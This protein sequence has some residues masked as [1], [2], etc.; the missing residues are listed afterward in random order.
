MSLLKNYTTALKSE[1]IKKK[2]TGAY[3]LC[4]SFGIII[5]LIYLIVMFFIWEENQQPVNIPYNFYEKNIGQT[6]PSFLGFFFPL[7]IIIVAAKITQIDHKNGGWQLM[8][9]QPLSKISIYLSKLTVLLIGNIIAIAAFLTSFVFFMWILSL[10][11]DVP[12]NVITDVPF[13]YLGQLIIRM[14]VAGL[15]LSIIQFVISVVFKSF[16]LPILIGFFAMLGTLILDGFQI[17]R[18]WNPFTI[19]SRTASNPTGSQ[20]NHFM[21]YT[22]KISIVGFI[23][24]ALIGFIWYQNKT[25]KRAFIKPKNLT[26][27]IGIAVLGILGIGF[28]LNPNIYEKHNRTVLLGTIESN[29]NIQKAYLVDRF[30]NDTL[31]EIDI[32]DNKFHTVIQKEIPLES[33][34]VIFKASNQFH[35]E[36]YMSTNDSIYMDIQYL[37]NTDNFKTTTGTRL[38]E[39]QYQSNNIMGNWSYANYLAND[40]SYLDRPERVINQIYK[41][42]KEKFDESDKFRTPDNYAPQN[43]FTELNKKITTVHYLMIWNNFEEKAKVVNPEIADNTPKKIK[44][45]KNHISLE[46]NSLITNE[47]YFNYVMYE[48]TKRDTTD[49]DLISK[50]MKAISQLE[51]KD[52]K[53]RLLFSSLKNSLKNASDSEERQELIRTYGE[54]ISNSK[55]KALAYN[56]FTTQE[57]LAKGNPAQDFVAQNLNDEDVKLSD[58]RGK[59]VIID[60]WATWCGPC[61]A[62]SPHFE[63]IAIKN[64]NNPEIVFLAVSIDKR[65]DNWYLQA[66]TKSE[67]VMQLHLSGEEK[68]AFEKAYD[69]EFIPRFIFIDKEGNFVNSKM[70][71]PSY[72]YF[73]TIINN[74]IK[75]K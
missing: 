2:G 47:D 10:I 25:F 41:E 74:E 40:N 11:K 1:F 8:E 45:I 54:E 34:Y 24:I 53:D 38:A 66:K 46:D 69:L 3:W 23:I 14:F 63:R 32:K 20:L 31:A 60:V 49:T 36:L 21:I 6:L 18:V 27:I 65:K 5:P 58:F 4:F 62:E 12:E 16:I 71:N 72:N 37:N 28:L 51:N 43:D 39:N 15:F 42:W 30:I 9:T 13:G 64:K 73:E 19:L 68:S 22:E 61:K 67:S 50:R 35:T 33:Y 52:F 70:L 57:K 7:L 59:Y 48:L 44:E 55:L 75:G 56:H 26:K 17:Y 29:E